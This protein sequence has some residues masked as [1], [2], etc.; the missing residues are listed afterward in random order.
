MK[1]P[2]SADKLFF[3]SALV[4]VV[5]F[6]IYTVLNFVW[7]L[8]L[9]PEETMQIPQIAN[10]LSQISWILSIAGVLTFVLGLVARKQ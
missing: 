10:V 9:S 6:V 1:G 5:S 8:P 4:F 2:L 3:I 7:P